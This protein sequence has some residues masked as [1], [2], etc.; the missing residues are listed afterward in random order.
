MFYC[1]TLVIS[2]PG[3]ILSYCVRL[4]IVVAAAKITALTLRSQLKEPT[5]E[6]NINRTSAHLE[7][8]DSNILY[9]NTVGFRAQSL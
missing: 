2:T 5:A 8:H 6:R 3:M 1:V 4:V 7:L 9:L